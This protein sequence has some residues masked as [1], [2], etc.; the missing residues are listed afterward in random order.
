MKKELIIAEDIHID[1]TRKLDSS[2]KLL[3]N[4]LDRS[5]KPLISPHED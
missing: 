1:S 5:D 4:N 3:N 2:R